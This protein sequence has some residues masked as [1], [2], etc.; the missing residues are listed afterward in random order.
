MGFEHE[1]IHIETSSVLIRELP[2]E[3]VREPIWVRLHLH[4]ELA[5]LHHVHVGRAHLDAGT[6]IISPCRSS[7]V[8][9][10]VEALDC[11]QNLQWLNDHVYPPATASLY[12][13][14]PYA[15]V[16]ELTSL[17]Y[18]IISIHA[19]SANLGCVVAEC[20][21]MCLLFMLARSRSLCSTPAVV[22]C[23]TSKSRSRSTV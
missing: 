5:V 22:V 12:H 15:L 8:A 18:P 11:N 2:L 4:Q 6:T 17:L 13:L 16:P 19:V 21:G 14:L 7:S 3:Y 1:R 23:Y 20:G 9:I 10:T